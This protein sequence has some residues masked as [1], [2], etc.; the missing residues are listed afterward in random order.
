MKYLFNSSIGRKLIMSL[1]G[2]FLI[3]FLVVHL[4]INLLLIIFESRDYFN[5]A[6]HFM[7]SN[8]VIKV[9]EIILFGGF[10]LHMVYGVI[11]YIINFIA[12]GQIRYKVTNN[13]QTSFFSKYMIHT[14]IVI[15]IF[16]VLHL[17]DFYINSKFL[18]DISTYYINNE[19]FHDLGLLVIKRFQIGWA[20]VIY[21]AALLGIGFHLQHGFQSAFQ[22]LGINHKF[23]SPLLK[24]IGIIYSIFISAGFILIPL[25]IYFL[26]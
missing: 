9:F 23:Y 26:K 24:K 17:F 6:S 2:L 15:T 18:G 3:T 8:T 11:L 25:Y 7:S 1:A 13:S 19:P 16:L 4:G 5:I 22:T 10:I 12:R 14:A 21:I 20:V